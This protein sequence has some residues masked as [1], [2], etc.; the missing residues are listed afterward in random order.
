MSQALI[1]TLFANVQTSKIVNFLKE[2]DLYK[3]F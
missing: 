3:H 2:I 1:G